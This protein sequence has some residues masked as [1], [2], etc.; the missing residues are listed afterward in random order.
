MAKVVIFLYLR[1]LTDDGEGDLLSEW[2]GKQGIVHTIHIAEEET[3]M[4]VLAQAVPVEVDASTHLVAVSGDVHCSARES[5]PP[6]PHRM[7][8]A[9]LN[10]L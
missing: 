4:S 9:Y 5:H 1:V 10:A 3:E 6:L 8:A 2:P 7:C